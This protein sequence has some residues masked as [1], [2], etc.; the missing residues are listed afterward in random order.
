MLLAKEK[1]NYYDVADYGRKTRKK[2]KTTRKYKK[3]PKVLLIL[4]IIAAFLMGLFLASKYAQ[5]AIS[6]YEIG[7]M[8][9]SLS[10]LQMQN[11]QLTLE[12]AKL[13]SLDRIEKIAVEK[14]G[15]GKPEG[16]QYVAVEPI[17]GSPSREEAGRE[18]ALNEKALL[19]GENAFIKA[20][21]VMIGNWSGKAE[22]GG[23][24]K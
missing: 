13:Q 11:E 2:I 1:V 22:A 15:M 6:G 3:N 18:V 16:I 19:K 7:K 9:D 10:K 12:V 14:L 5:L 17:T 23:R 21:A 24:V 8:K 20:F 4:F